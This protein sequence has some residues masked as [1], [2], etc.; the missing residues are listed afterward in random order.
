MR[1]SSV[2]PLH[3][4]SPWLLRTRQYKY[5]YLQL[6][7]E[8]VIPVSGNV[9]GAVSFADQ[10]GAAMYDTN[11]KGVAFIIQTFDSNWWSGIGRNKDKTLVV[12]VFFNKEEGDL[13]LNEREDKETERIE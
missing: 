12:L 8:G 7:W 10:I 5:G 9:G 6:L 4:Y 11:R 1:R 13:E 3:P 2:R